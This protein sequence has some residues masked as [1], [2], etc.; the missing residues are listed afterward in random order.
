VEIKEPE[1]SPEKKKEKTI[2]H[3]PIQAEPRKSEVKQPNKIAVEEIQLSEGILNC[4]S[5]EDD[6]AD[7]PFGAE[8]QSSIEQSADKFKNFNDDNLGE[9]FD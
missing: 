9:S 5:D 2:V 6:K 1:P 7:N 3:I 8:N 4:S